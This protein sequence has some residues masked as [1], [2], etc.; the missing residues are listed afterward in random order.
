MRQRVAERDLRIELVRILAIT[1]RLERHDDVS[2]VTLRANV[3]L[4]VELAAVKLGKN[5]IG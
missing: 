5:L 3:R 2:V 4:G 1:R